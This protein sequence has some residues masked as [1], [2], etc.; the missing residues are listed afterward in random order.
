MKH[1]TLDGLWAIT[2]YFNPLGYG[3]RL[4]NYRVFREHLDVPLLTVEQQ[5]P[6][7]FELA[8]S[9]AEI[10]VQIPTDDVLWQKERLLNLAVESLP[11][12]CKYV[13]WLDCDIIF[14]RDDWMS[15][16]VNKLD[17][18]VMV[19]LFSRTL[20]L[21]AEVD[22][23]ADLE[24]QSYLERRSTA[25]GILDGS[26]EANPL[27]PGLE[28]LKKHGMG[29][30]FSNGHAWIMRRELL[31]VVGFYEAMVVGGGDY[32]FL[33]AAL[34]KFEVVRDSHGWTDP[35][36]PQYRHFLS[37]AKPFFEIVQ[38]RIGNVTGDIFNLWHGE[39]TNRSYLPR[40]EILTSHQFDPDLDITIDDHGSL[41]W[42]SDKPELHQLVRDYFKGRQEDGQ[43]KV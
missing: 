43:P 26:V 16:A 19:Q 6:G 34:G 30:Q 12:E 27:G 13:V 36:S 29:S 20:Y 21:P 31:Q 41:R 2:S 32:V 25:S 23:S 11:P 18:Y 9:D 15:E 14:S 7:C 22:Y 10:L 33:Q 1:S 40:H 5:F 28:V 17:D 37:W 42:N 35:N 24:T 4:K 39:L 3:S 8:E 38:G